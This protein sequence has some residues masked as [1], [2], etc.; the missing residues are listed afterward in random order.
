MDSGSTDDTVEIATHL[1]ARIVSRPFD[2]FSGQR[3]FALETVQFKHDWILHLDADEVVTTEFVAALAA[4]GLSDGFDGA[5]VPSKTILLDQWL[6]YAGMYPTYQVRI[7][8]AH[9]LRFVEVGHGQREVSPPER[10]KTFPVPYLHYNF[11]HGLRPWLDKHVRYAAAEA[12]ERFKDQDLGSGRLRDIFSM[13]ATTRRR[14]AKALSQV[15]PITLRP[16]A[17]FLYVYVWRR[18]FLDGTAGLMY[19][20]MMAVYE[21]MISIL[22]WERRRSTSSTKSVHRN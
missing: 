15:V 18:G 8:H 11:S 21:G 2:N 13:D 19:A 17:R 20:F 1:G 12:S 5:R 3:N 14:S 6:K 9:R 10:I 16:L 4:F 22:I 7:G